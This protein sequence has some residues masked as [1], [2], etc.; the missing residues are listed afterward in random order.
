MLLSPTGKLGQRKL[1]KL[2]NVG[3]EALY[4][5]ILVLKLTGLTNKPDLIVKSKERT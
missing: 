5:N 4:C 3:V 1:C 2:L